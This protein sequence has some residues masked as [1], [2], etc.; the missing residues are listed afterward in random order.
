MVEKYLWSLKDLNSIFEKYDKKNPNFWDT[1][2]GWFDNA[3][4]RK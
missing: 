3:T 1:I 4:G 2:L